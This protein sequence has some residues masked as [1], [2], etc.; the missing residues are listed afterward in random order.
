MVDDVKLNLKSK[1]KQIL[2]EFTKLSNDCSFILDLLYQNFTDITFSKKELK[3]IEQSLKRA[4]KFKLRININALYYLANRSLN[5][6]QFK[7]DKNYVENLK[8]K[9]QLITPII[10][11]EL[12]LQYDPD[13]PHTQQSN[14]ISVLLRIQIISIN[15]YN[16]IKNPYFDFFSNDLKK[17]IYILGC[18]LILEIQN[19]MDN[20]Q[21]NVNRFYHN[22][23]ENYNDKLK[24]LNQS[25]KKL[26]KNIQKKQ[27]QYMK[28]EDFNI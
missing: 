11:R 8:T 7:K 27:K 28:F 6:D 23:K 19:F 25:I 13:Y 21:N 22:L 9:Y 15:I 10:G 18:Q 16:I 1:P 3:N 24:N 5:V 2:I 20:P 17:N 12:Q 14:I 26:E 4:I